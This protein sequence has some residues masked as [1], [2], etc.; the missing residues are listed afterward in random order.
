MDITAKL[1]ALLEAA[2]RVGITVRRAPLGGEGGGLCRIKGERVLFVDI[3]ADALTQYSRTLA[4]LS[5]LPDFH[6][7]YLPPDVRADLD[8][9]P[10]A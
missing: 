2:E 10:S 8:A 1:A 7:L 6:Q 4:D 9:Y 5:Q 3:N